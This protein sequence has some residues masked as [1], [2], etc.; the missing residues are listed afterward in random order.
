[1][2]S[3]GFCLKIIQLIFWLDC[4]SSIG[5][6]EKQQKMLHQRLANVTSILEQRRKQRKYSEMEGGSFNRSFDY[7][8]IDSEVCSPVTL[9]PSTNEIW[10]EKDNFRFN[11]S[12]YELP[13]SPDQD[14]NIQTSNNFSNHTDQDC[15][16]NGDHSPTQE[17]NS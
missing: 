1:M 8:I 6:L 13:S 5:E 17:S 16:C 14:T 11:P 9:K 15:S 10:A 12:S 7:T 3:I 4:S 2:K